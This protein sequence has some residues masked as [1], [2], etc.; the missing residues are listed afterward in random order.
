MTQM[1]Q[2][3]ETTAQEVTTMVNGTSVAPMILG[4]LY[5]S[6]DVGTTKVCTLIAQV[7]PAGE[8]EIVGTGDRIPTLPFNGFGEW[9]GELYGGAVTPLGDVPHSP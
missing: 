1:A 7:S 8:L 6:I 2:K 9:V 4:N 3:V 5:V